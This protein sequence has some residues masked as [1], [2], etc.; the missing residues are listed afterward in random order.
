MP[1][2]YDETW[3]ARVQ[4]EWMRLALESFGAWSSRKNPQVQDMVQAHQKGEQAQVKLL[5]NPV[6][7]SEGP[8]GQ[9]TLF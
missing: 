3:C 9:L 2:L 7:L 1:A 4:L 8:G 6:P 5:G